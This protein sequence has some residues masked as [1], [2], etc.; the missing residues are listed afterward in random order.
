MS[1]TSLVNMLKQK[2]KDFLHESFMSIDFKNAV[3]K[4]KETEDYYQSTTGEHFDVPFKFIGKRHFATIGP[5]Q[6]IKEIRNLYELVKSEN[7]KTILEIGTDKGGTLYLWCKAASEDAT[8]VSIDLSSRRRYSPQR[9]KLYAKFKK[10]ASQKLHFLPFS[11]HDQTTVDKA[12]S[13][14]DEK[15][16]DYLFI[17]GDHTYEGVKSDYYMFNHMVKKG[18]LIAFHDIKT[19]R[20][21]CGVRELW[22]EVTKEMNK[23]DFWEYAENDYGPLGAGI[24]VIRKT[25]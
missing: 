24:G 15:K 25:W 23:A 19:V 14:F 4:L 6:V 9:R 20:Q 11:S 1:S 12:M 16:I 18:G 7:P 5:S 8:I 3:K 13:L 10:S 17:D 21:D 22:E 2:V